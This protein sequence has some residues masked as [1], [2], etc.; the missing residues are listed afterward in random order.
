LSPQERAQKLQL[1]PRDCAVH[2]LLDGPKPE[3]VAA[4]ADGGSPS[5]KLLWP[6]NGGKLLRGLGTFRLLH[7]RPE[8]RR[9][10]NKRVKPRKHHHLGLDIG[11][12][13]GADI[14]AAQN[15]LVVYS[16][17]GLRGYGNLITVVHA[18]ATIAMY[19]HCKLSKVKPGE[20]V[21]RGQ[22]LGEVGHTGYAKGPHL[23]FEFRVAGEP[24][25]PSDRFDAH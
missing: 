9:G 15:G 3:W 5:P 24:I 12:D 6:V 13:E 21:T 1:G 7:V 4:A 22:V 8:P 2:L 25:D 16:G 11:G 10:T 19:A 17:H 18:D 14:L 23:H 20:L